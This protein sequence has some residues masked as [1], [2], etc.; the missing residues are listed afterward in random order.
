MPVIPVIYSHVFTETH[1][2]TRDPPIVFPFL[3]KRSSLTLMHLPSLVSTSLME[4]IQRSWIY[5]FFLPP[6]PSLPRTPNWIVWRLMERPRYGQL[7][8][9]RGSSVVMG[10]DPHHATAVCSPSTCTYMIGLALPYH[11]PPP[12]NPPPRWRGSLHFVTARY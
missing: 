4:V 7:I 5:V 6:P 2:I 12:A 1:S 3:K 11:S 9:R 10:G 8:R